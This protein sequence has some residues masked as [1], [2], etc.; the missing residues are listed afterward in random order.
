MN[1]RG[2]E[3]QIPDYIEVFGR[4]RRLRDGTVAVAPGN[5]MRGGA[6]FTEML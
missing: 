5:W 6:D 4:R 2:A 1:S 3:C